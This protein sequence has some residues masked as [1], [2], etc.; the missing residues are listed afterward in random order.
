MPP[1]TPFPKSPPCFMAFNEWEIWYG[2]GTFSTLSEL[3]MPSGRSARTLFCTVA[4]HIFT[5]K[6]LCS[7]K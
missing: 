1:P 5:L 3:A 2:S 6:T 7:E 4:H